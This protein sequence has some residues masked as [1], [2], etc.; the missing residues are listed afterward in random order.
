MYVSVIMLPTVAAPRVCHD[1]GDLWHTG[2]HQRSVIMKN[3]WCRGQLR[4]IAETSGRYAEVC[5]R[6]NRWVGSGVV[7]GMSRSPNDAVADL[8]SASYGRLVGV[9]ALVAESRA[10]AEECVQEAFVRLLGRWD[11]VSPARSYRWAAVWSSR[12]APPGH[13]FGGSQALCGSEGR[14]A[15]SSRRLPAGAASSR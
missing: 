15:A 13:R 4:M 10:D 8:Y 5:L 3:R 7:V 6:G 9:V 12:R 14:A 2:V 11:R 1:P